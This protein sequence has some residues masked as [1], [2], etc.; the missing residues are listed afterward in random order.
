M[1]ISWLW[2]IPYF[3]L[4]FFAFITTVIAFSGGL[5]HFDKQQNK[6][7]LV[8]VVVVIITTI[9][10][11][12][13]NLFTIIQ[14]IT[15]GFVVVGVLFLSM[16]YKKILFDW[17][18]RV[19]S[20]VLIITLSAWLLYL[21]GIQFPHGPMV[22][23][24][25]GFHYMYNF[26]FFVVSAG[27]IG[28]ETPR[29][30]S[31]FMEPGWVGTMCCFV[32]FGIRFDRKSYTTYLCLFGI[33][34][35]LSLSAIVNLVVCGLLWTVVAG[36]KKNRFIY[37]LGAS[38]LVASMFLF[39]VFYKGG[40]NALN[41]KVV[42]RLAY[43]EDLGIV[44]NN[45]TNDVFESEF[46]YVMNSSDRWFGIGDGIDRDFME[47]N[48]WYSHS[49]GIKKDIIDNGLIGAGLYLLLLFLL[50]IRYKN[51]PCLIFLI[52]FLMASFIR[53][54]W[55]CDFYLIFYILTLSVLWSEGQFSTSLN[56]KTDGTIIKTEN[57]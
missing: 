29:F 10:S 36:N 3:W 21:V 39:A 19:F 55:R 28:A 8:Y 57:D 20:F 42:E 50:Y 45:R 16:Q 12:Y 4:V 5:F 6:A 15:H 54:L 41:R 18:V 31:V 56:R 9:R 24:G 27:S 47:T 14:N 33:L 52:C 49:S 35:S 44:G 53:N 43:D 23:M 37:W 38:A 51:K 13:L 48:K 26:G 1:S 2:S 7:L 32:L 22:D 25:D 11:P 46:E 17:F 30:A 34:L 40:N